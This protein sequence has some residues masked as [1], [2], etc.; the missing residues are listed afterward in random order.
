MQLLGLTGRPH[1]ALHHVQESR[2]A[3]KMRAH[4][5]LLCGDYPSNELL[6]RHQKSD[7]KCYLC[8]APVESTQHILTEC[9]ATSEVRDRLLPELLNV[10]AQIEP[11]N[12]LLDPF[13][14][15]STLTQFILDPTSLNLDNQFRFSPQHPQLHKLYSISRDWCFAVTSSRTYQ[16]RLLVNNSV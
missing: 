7:P 13:L 3:F 15:K 10:V 16:L 9:R 11:K 12:G 6:A 5:K 14:P 2:V 8:S 1:P 4:T